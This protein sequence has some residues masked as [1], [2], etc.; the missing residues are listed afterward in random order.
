MEN[1]QFFCA[2]SVLYCLCYE[3]DYFKISLQNIYK[4]T[5]I[6]YEILMT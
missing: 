6:D 4:E 2:R 3:A 5:Q 1:V